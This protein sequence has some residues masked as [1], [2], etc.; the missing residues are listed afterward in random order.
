MDRP[1]WEQ[2]KTKTIKQ[3][4]NT[5]DFRYS[6]AKSL[7]CGYY[8]IFKG[9]C[10]TSPKAKEARERFQT[11]LVNPQLGI[12]EV[13]GQRVTEFAKKYHL[14]KSEL[15]KLVCHR[16]LGYRGWYLERTLH[17]AQVRLM[18]GTSKS[19]VLI[20]VHS[21]SPYCIYMS[22]VTPPNIRARR[23]IKMAILLAVLAAVLA[24]SVPSWTAALQRRRTDRALAKAKIT[25]VAL[26]YYALDHHGLLP[27]S[28]DALLSSY[29]A[30]DDI[31]KNVNLL[32]PGAELDNLKPE[33]VILQVTLPNDYV[34]I[35]HADGMVETARAIA[36]R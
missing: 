33:T 6:N 13:L 30:N 10:S 4:A 22:L 29:V 11:V 36:N 3:F 32:A 26:K 23:L 17:L 31:I 21:I 35:C 28:L 20:G 7:A 8:K 9:W 14:C 27:D 2:I 5:Y 34:A 24:A 1:G 12:R 15:H 16:K 18:F 19:G 25:G